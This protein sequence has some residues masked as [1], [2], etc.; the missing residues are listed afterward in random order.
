LRDWLLL[1]AWEAGV[2][3]VGVQPVPDDAT[4]EDH[5]A[6]AAALNDFTGDA[7]I[8]DRTPDQTA[9]ALVAAARGYHRREDKPFWWAHFD[10][11]NYPVDEWAYSTA[12]SSAKPRSKRSGIHHP[13]RASRSGGC[14]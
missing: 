8:D 2:T 5:D 12:V 6:L 4:I 7:A 14:D 1:R 13:A 10:R 3:P 9:V 11:L